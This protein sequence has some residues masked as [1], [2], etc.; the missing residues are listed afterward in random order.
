MNLTVL[1]PPRVAAADE[2]VAVLE[3]ALAEA[4][5]GRLRAIA[6]ATLTTDFQA[7]H[8]SV[9]GDSWAG[10]VGAVAAMQHDM[11]AGPNDD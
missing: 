10:I 5:E 1:T 2:I 4:R 11:I 9:I 7:E 8:V 3:D 6:L